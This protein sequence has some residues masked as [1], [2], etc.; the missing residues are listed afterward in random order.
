MLIFSSIEHVPTNYF[1]KMI[2]Y[3]FLILTTMVLFSC[4]QKHSPAEMI[5]SGGKIYTMDVTNPSVEAVAVTAGKILFAGPASE[6]EKYKGEA[7]QIIDLKGNTMTPGFIESHGHFMGLGYNE[8]EL[9]LMD[10]KSWDEIV[11]RVKAAAENAQ[12][13]EWII[14]RGWHQD[15]WDKKPEKMVKGFQ[16]HQ[17]LSEASP[18]NPVFLQ[19]ASGHAGFANAKA[20]Q[21]AGVNQMSIEKMAKDLGEGGEVIRDELGNPTGLF[22]ERA[23]GLIYQH[24]PENT[25]ETDARAFTL[26]MDACAREGITSFHD[27]GASRKEIELFKK[28]RHENNMKTRLYVMITG[29]DPE[30]VYEW[31]RKGPEIDSTNFLTIRSIKLNCDGA[32]GSRGAWL[33]EPYSDRPDWY[34]MPTLSMDTVLSVSKNA[35]KAGFQV[36]SHAIGDRANREI[37]DR[38]EIAFNENQDAANDHRFRIEHAQH[39]HPDDILRFAKM[40]VIAA[41][42]G[43]HLS[44]DRPW[45]IDRLGEKRIV[46]ETYVWQ[47][48]LKSG[49]M[50]INGSDV[51]VEPISPVA[52][53]Y[54]SVTRRTLDGRP[55]GGYE[56]NQKM[57]REQALRSYT[58]DAAYGAFQEKDLGSIEVGKAA[59]F[60]VFT[61][62]LMTVEEDKLL[63]TEIAKTIVNGKIVYEK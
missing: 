54:A 26:A 45:A 27:A 24:V 63:D 48:F 61:Q 32:L 50:I 53:F 1:D 15:K 28:F 34:G 19:H 62:D 23:Q 47:D 4:G 60:T 8:I 40:N 21:I 17:L 42:Q 2:K 6:V 14:G 44:S 7:T 56:P 10:T 58:L 57:T 59:D 43:I 33:L 3:A 29:R 31:M 12:P 16:T 37:L 11:A 20:M 18:D 55:E 36:C 5:I 13:G 39:V 35:L 9:D 41:M 25:E 30:L 22:N 49:A 52:S 51:P 46:E 38:Y